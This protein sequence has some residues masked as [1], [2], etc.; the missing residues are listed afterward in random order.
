MSILHKKGIAGVVALGI[1]TGSLGGN[2]EGLDG[3]RFA[4]KEAMLKACVT[5]AS[6]TAISV[7]SESAVSDAVSGNCITV[8]AGAVTPIVE[9]VTSSSLNQKE[10][11]VITSAVPA[12]TSGD[13]LETTPTASPE[14]TVVR[15]TATPFVEKKGWNTISTKKKYYIKKDGTKAVGY[16]KIGGSYYYFKNN[17]YVLMEKW[18][19]V[20]IDNRKYKLYFDKNGKQKQN[21]ASLIGEQ[22]SYRLE[23]NIK[24]NVVIAYAKDGDKGY[25]IPVKAMVC[26]CG[27]AGHSTITGT[28]NRLTKAGVWHNLY[29]GTYGKY[30]T[31]INGPYLFHSV[32]YKK[33]GDNYSLDAA[34]FAKLGKLASHGCI[35]M[36]VKDAKWIY[37]RSGKVAS[38]YLYRSNDRLPLSKPKA[39]EAVVLD[40]GKAY[41]P[42]DKSVK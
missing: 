38:T 26:S 35:R 3:E 36:Q 4:R 10:T 5:V 33:Y 37:N 27:V 25:T 9:P 24:K 20:K 23:V 13:N 32:V 12:D 16:V 28:Y 7:V 39:S 17:G 11:E 34:E 29:Y 2:C 18:K 15:P 30:C 1:L 42:T 8:S 40:N 19:Y 6:E 31:R 41:D 21:V 14:E 22:D